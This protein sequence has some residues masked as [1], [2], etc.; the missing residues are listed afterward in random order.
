MAK[1]DNTMFPGKINKKNLRRNPVQYEIEK[2]VFKEEFGSEMFLDVP[3]YTAKKKSSDTKSSVQR[4]NSETITANKNSFKEE[5]SDV[6]ATDVSSQGVQSYSKAG[7]VFEKISE[8]QARINY[9]GMLANS[10]AQSI[11]GV[12]G[13]GSNQ[14]WENVSEAEFKKDGTGFSAIIPIEQGK[15][16]N[17]AFKDNAENWDNNLGMNYTFVN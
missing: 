5:F 7:V 17:L 15:N 3:A 8:N 2:D 13:F 14:K 10:G 1:F 6:I 9:N 16:L 11:T 4:N 12:Y